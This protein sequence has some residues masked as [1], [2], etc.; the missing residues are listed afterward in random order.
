MAGNVVENGRMNLGENTRIARSIL[1]VCISSARDLYFL[2]G[3][4]DDGIMEWTLKI[5]YIHWLKLIIWP[6]G[7][8]VAAIVEKGM[9]D[10]T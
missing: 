3:Q 5:N 7:S 1:Y 4:I 6:G 10:M 9:E 8:V 2:W